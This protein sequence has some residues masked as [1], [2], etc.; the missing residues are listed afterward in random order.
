MADLAGGVLYG[1][2]LG[3]YFVKTNSPVSAMRFIFEREWIISN[4]IADYFITYLITLL[5]IN[6]KFNTIFDK[7]RIF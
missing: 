5:P 4:C 3:G 2:M 6:L 1:A 7:L